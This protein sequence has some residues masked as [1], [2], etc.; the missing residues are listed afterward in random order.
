[1]TNT[2]YQKLSR[3]DIAVALDSTTSRFCVMYKELET[4]AN[5]AKTWSIDESQLLDNVLL[6]GASHKDYHKVGE[7][8]KENLSLFTSDIVTDDSSYLQQTKEHTL[9]VRACLLASQKLWKMGV[10]LETAMLNYPMVLRNM[11]SKNYRGIDKL[12]S[13]Y[14]HFFNELQTLVEE[15][16]RHL[17]FSVRAIS[18]YA[19]AHT[20]LH[21]QTIRTLTTVSK[22]KPMLLEFTQT[23]NQFVASSHPAVRRDAVMA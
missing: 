8:L 17:H 19:P 11:R 14:N 20:S 15:R 21:R 3:I 7:A 23:H 22:L 16:V 10:N 5:A 6:A 13:L 9:D 4:F 18:L 12:D 1:M 2:A